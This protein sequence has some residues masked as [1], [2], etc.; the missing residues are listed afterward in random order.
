M[1]SVNT[2]QSCAE[3][4]QYTSGRWLWDEEQQL[5]DRYTPF[6]V[7]ELQKVAAHSVG[8][9]ECI[10][11]TKLAEGSFNKTFKLSMDNGLNVIARIPHPIAGPK[12]Y[13]TAS[14]VATMEF[15]RSILE[16]PVPRVYAWNADPNHPV[17]SEFI[18][19]EEAPGANLDD[20]WHDLPLEEKV[21]ITKDLVSLEKK[22]LSVSLNKYGNL[23]FANELIQGAAAA[24]IRGIVPEETRKAVQDR[25]IIGPV[26]ER[27]YWTK[28]RA[29]M[30]LDRGPWEM[31]QQYAI[32]L[33]CREIEWIKQYATPRPHG[34]PLMSSASQNSPEHHISLLQKYLKVARF[35]LPEDPDLVAP[36]I[37]HTDLHPGNLFVSEGRISCVIDW[38]GIWAAPL[39]LRARH[40]RL[41]D[42]QGDIVLKPP[43]NFNDL[44]AE[45][46]K[47]IREKM[48]KSIV[49]YL[50]EKQIAKEAPL[51]NR[52]LHLSH[53]RT[54]CDP[55]Q[56]WRE[57][58]FDF[59]CPIHFTEEELRTHVEESE[60]WNDVQEFWNSVANIVTREG[61]TP[62]HLYNDAVT[63]F[64][65]LRDT[66]LKTMTGKER[67][68]FMKQ[69][70]WVEKA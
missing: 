10:N 15:A 28:E 30:R 60:G 13:T 1:S 47:T 64:A 70:Q 32:S 6:N 42:Y 11:M 59:P 40:P 67:E 65:E 19:M 55:I 56:Y 29:S 27:G 35:L 17:G 36:H 66:G 41:V 38:Q 48:S 46:K 44:D 45:Q 18:I 25:F 3:F 61:W 50:Y 49:I 23:Y 16:I 26:A 31:P 20:I 51:L 14:E 22:M 58:E 39:L 57:L 2:Q 9:K 7:P 5:R 68:D 24:D 52:V 8:A 12:Y 33:A 43:A 69:T 37:W 63:L 4:F 62:N 53:G 54:R 21:A 34:D